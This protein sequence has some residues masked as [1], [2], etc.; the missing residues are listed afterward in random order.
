MTI[1]VTDKDFK[2]IWSLAGQIFCGCF[3]CRVFDKE[4]GRKVLQPNPPTQRRRTWRKDF[5]PEDPCARIC[6][7]KP[8]P[9]KTW[10]HIF[11]QFIVSFPSCLPVENRSSLVIYIILNRLSI[12]LFWSQNS[13][14]GT[15]QTENK[16]SV[17]VRMA[18]R[19]NNSI[20]F[21]FTFSS[22]KK[23][24]RKTDYCAMIKC[25]SDGQSDWG[26]CGL[27]PQVLEGQILQGNKHHTSLARVIFAGNFEPFRFA[28]SF[29]VSTA[30]L[31][32]AWVTNHLGDSLK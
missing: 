24:R 31:M 25:Y 29:I 20:A 15:Y 1:S 8:G 27:T 19:L 22:W 12:I 7:S 4:R 2:N 9:L 16:T 28:M 10:K 23:E 26:N 30:S 21:T 14:T 5:H 18:G 17:T 13:E 3:T 6:H 11:P 32:R